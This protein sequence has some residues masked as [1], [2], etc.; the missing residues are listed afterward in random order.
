MYLQRFFFFYVIAG[1]THPWPWIMETELHLKSPT[2]L[3]HEVILDD[4]SRI[5]QVFVFYFVNKMPKLTLCDLSR[6]RATD[7]PTKVSMRVWILFCSACDPQTSQGWT[8][9]GSM[10]AGI[11]TSATSSLWTG[12]FPRISF[13]YYWIYNDGRKQYNI[14]LYFTESW[15]CLFLYL[16]TGF[17]ESKWTMKFNDV[18]KKG[19]SLIQI[20][21]WERHI[22]LD[23]AKKLVTWYPKLA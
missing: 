3:E 5:L 13:L 2:F 20:T 12:L 21:L 14:V 15:Y 8:L 9:S 23:A 6:K 11:W 18:N 10:L 1:V 19:H 16:L 4:F 22:H 7:A 17:I